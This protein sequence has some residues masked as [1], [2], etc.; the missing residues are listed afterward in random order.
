[1]TNEN[2]MIEN[3]LILIDEALKSE[4]SRIL[5]SIK[6]NYWVYPKDMVKL[7]QKIK[8]VK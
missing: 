2:E 7:I 3:Y 8:E 5:K 6:D 4:R 1:M